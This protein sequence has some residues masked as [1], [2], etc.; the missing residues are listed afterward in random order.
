MG[1][2]QRPVLSKGRLG[3][4]DLLMS[5][6]LEKLR[7]LVTFL[8]AP[9]LRLLTWFHLHWIV[10]RP[11][12]LPILTSVAFSVAMLFLPQGR[13]VLYRLAGQ[14]T[15]GPWG[16]F[17]W[18]LGLLAIFV[19]SASVVYVSRIVLAVDYPPIREAR[20]RHQSEAKN[21]AWIADREASL[22]KWAPDL[23]AILPFVAAATVFLLDAIHPEPGPNVPDPARVPNGWSWIAFSAV[24]LLGVITV[25][26]AFRHRLFGLP[27]ADHHR[28]LPTIPDGSWEVF[29][30]VAVVA[31]G[32]GLYFWLAPTFLPLHIGIGSIVTLGAAA[33]IFAF[34]S[35]FVVL[36]T[37]LVAHPSN[38]LHRL[39]LP[40][41]AWAAL[42][43]AGYLARTGWTDNH[44][45]RTLPEATA[46][47]ERELIA[48]RPKL[49]QRLARWLLDRREAA[50]NPDRPYPLIVA[51][52]QGGGIRAAMWSAVSLGQ[53]Q[54]R[55]QRFTCHLFA[56]AG[57]SGGSLGALA[58]DALLHDRYRP[59]SAPPCNQKTG[60]ADASQ[61]LKEVDTGADH[62][63]S[64]AIRIFSDDFLAA[65]TSGMLF[66]DL[67][68]RFVPTA[69]LPWS[70]LHLPDRQYYLELGLENAWRGYQVDQ[71]RADSSEFA[72]GQGFLSLIER[73]PGETYDPALF[74]IASEIDT[75]R[76]W[77]AS[78]VRVDP[79]IF[80]H[81]IDALT[82][83]SLKDEDEVSV[84]PN[85]LAM[86]AST[87]AG[88]SARFP[89]IS[90]PGTVPVPDAERADMPRVLD[91]G[92]V[93][94]SGAGTAADILGALRGWCRVVPTEDHQP[95]IALA[96]RP[97][98]EPDP[99]DP[100]RTV[101]RVVRCLPPEAGCL[102]IR[103]VAL[104]L[105]N[106]GYD[107]EQTTDG[108]N[109]NAH[110]PSL[111]K[112]LPLFVETLSPI[113][114]LLQ[115]RSGR[116]QEIHDALALGADLRRQDAASA[117]L[118]L[119]LEELGGSR[120]DERVPLTWAIIDQSGATMRE[121]I[122]NQLKNDQAVVSTI[123]EVFGSV[124]SSSPN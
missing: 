81:A 51:A 14:P 19:F 118:E 44:G 45:I 124:T 68:A 98:D 77:I 107:Q 30:W 82:G 86:P 58:F 67:L 69:G 74:L 12:A 59:T 53:L 46:G 49:E 48:E 24:V 40:G 16:W 70:W 50:G 95:A 108:S 88:N 18:A 11:A 57:I 110:L 101:S 39:S 90:P 106:D 115:S 62:F 29:V 99:K 60:R 22:R 104:Q 71:A 116:G 61:L 100:R 80:V 102:L 13:E 120:L 41:V 87:A 52:A 83:Q 123:Q 15:G 27:Q 114:A 42:L 1:W 93:E 38:A 28:L 73:K 2:I 66:P 97:I 25:V 6:L 91:G 122:V 64:A 26:L 105:T 33:V 8:F 9:L 55:D 89:W 76:R 54:D 47:L 3:R 79:K 4:G 84:G 56:I 7:A 34:G 65:I 121:R 78:D 32:L 10:L 92:I 20:E 37:F 72:L 117:H 94:S 112:A 113:G 111:R 23:A 75:G 31:M 96:C 36:G 109:Q 119:N 17:G 5:H 85:L 63:T 43:L 21:P 103:P 35:C